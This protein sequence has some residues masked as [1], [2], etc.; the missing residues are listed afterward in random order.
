MESSLTSHSTGWLRSFSLRGASPP[1]RRMDPRR[2]TRSSSD[3]ILSRSKA[4]STL[5]WRWERMRWT[6][7]SLITRG[8]RFNREGKK[9]TWWVVEINM[10]EN[11][12]KYWL[13]EREKES[14]NHN[15]AQDKILAIRTVEL[16]QFEVVCFCFSVID[17]L[18][19]DWLI[20]W[21]T[22]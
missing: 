8:I 21:L 20:Y 2:F 12:T 4:Q 19:I 17:C 16:M 18:I 5:R 13:C 11:W 10:D 15:K 1:S 9:K 22:G 7:S 3:L 6:I 14:D